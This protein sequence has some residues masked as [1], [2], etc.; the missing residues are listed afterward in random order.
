MKKLLLIATIYILGLGGIIY[1]QESKYADGTIAGYVSFKGYL[2]PLSA[3]FG[4]FDILYKKYIYDLKNNPNV[5]TEELKRI[6]TYAPKNI[7]ETIKIID[8]YIDSISAVKIIQK[9]YEDFILIKKY[10]ENFKEYFDGLY[11]SKSYFYLDYPP[12]FK[13]SHY[14]DTGLVLMFSSMCGH[15]IFNSDKSTQNERAKSVLIDDA[16]PL[17]NNY[18][19]IPDCKIKYVMI[20]C[21][22]HCANFN[23]E[24]YKYEEYKLECVTILVPVIVAK[25]YSK[26]TITKDDLI[27]KSYVYLS[28]DNF[29]GE[30]VKV[31]LELN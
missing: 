4:L 1:A 8:N 27:A 9:D 5:D 15:Q 25:E 10:S 31:K 6:Y 14:Y 3:K 16:I 11:Y 17:L 23:D 26:K 2:K 20:P 22:Y 30:M 24:N 18:D 7:S 12:P 21:M 19:L 29:G 13:F 28:D